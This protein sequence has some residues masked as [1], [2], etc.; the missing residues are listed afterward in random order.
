MQLEPKYQI[1]DTIFC[2][3]IDDYLYGLIEEIH[4]K[5]DEIIYVIVFDSSCF[6][7]DPMYLVEKDILVR[8]YALQRLDKRL[9][10][11]TKETEEW[12]VKNRD[13]IKEEG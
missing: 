2:E 1:G 7:C 10:E 5:S 13:M 8:S 4:I 11:K 9:Q 12:Y 6:R 3:N